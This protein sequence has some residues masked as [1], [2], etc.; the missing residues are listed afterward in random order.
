MKRA[1][2]QKKETQAN[3]SKGRVPQQIKIIHVYNFV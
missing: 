3:Q 1:N 2:A